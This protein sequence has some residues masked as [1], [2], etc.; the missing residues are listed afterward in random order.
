MEYD[1]AE[2][3]RQY[4]LNF[5]RGESLWDDPIPPEI[6]SDVIGIQTTM[7]I[8]RT[9]L[10]ACSLLNISHVETADLAFDGWIKLLIRT[11]TSFDEAAFKREIT[12]IVA[13]VKQL[14]SQNDH[15]SDLVSA[16]P[17]SLA[18]AFPFREMQTAW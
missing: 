11:S 17:A 14:R 13:G 7:T 3:S 5:D 18:S 6:T 4:R 12:D 16:A 1:T 8:N 15:L 2:I 9:S 10:L